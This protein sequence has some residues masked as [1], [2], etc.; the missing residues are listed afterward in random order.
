MPRRLLYLTR[1][2]QLPC[3]KSF[4][5]IELARFISFTFINASPQGQTILINA[6]VPILVVFQSLKYLYRPAT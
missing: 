1:T 5:A 2:F 4:S 6:N 3:V